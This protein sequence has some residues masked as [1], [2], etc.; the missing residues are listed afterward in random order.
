[1][2]IWSDFFPNV[3]PHVLGCP[4]PLLAQE[5][6]RAAQEFL[7]RTRAWKVWLDPTV[8]QDGAV[9]YDLDI[10]FG[11]VVVRVEKASA[12]GAP[13]DVLSPGT[14]LG[15]WADGGFA[16]SGLLSAD[17]ATFRLGRAQQGGKT[18]SIQASLMPSERAV[19]IP[20]ELYSQYADPIGYG[21]K[22]RLMA[23]P[24]QAWSNV[25]L[26]SANTVMFERAVQS[27]SVDAWRGHTNS[28]PRARVAWC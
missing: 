3:L 9:E 5:L 13:L 10:P 22:A 8:T 25:D 26:A 28:T 24:G 15:D 4:D 18:L 12:A 7:R 19:G 27:A 6:R 2:A 20:N 11:S 23:I 21:A 14:Q 1:M 16:G 17:R